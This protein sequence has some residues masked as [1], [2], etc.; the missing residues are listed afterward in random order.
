MKLSNNSLLKY[1]A[2]AYM[3]ATPAKFGGRALSGR[4][5]GADNTTASVLAVF[6]ARRIPYML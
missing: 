6:G 1:L 2:K 4:L 5:Y 3:R